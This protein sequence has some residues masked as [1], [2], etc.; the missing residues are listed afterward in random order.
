M[1]DS[2]VR[3]LAAVASLAITLVS[4]WRAA[5]QRP[6]DTPDPCPLDLPSFP[7]SPAERGPGVPSPAFDLRCI[8]LHATAMGGSAR[9]VVEL[10]RVPSPFGVAVS[11]DGHH[12][13]D[14]V[15]RI[16]G[17]PPVSSL[18]P[19]TTYI[20]WATPLE[21]DP[22]IKLGEVTDGSRALGAIEFNK[23]MIF[24][25][26]EPSTDVSE[27]TG[28][29]ILRGRSPSSRMEAHD[30][31]AQAPSAEEAGQAGHTHGTGEDG[32][33]M[34]P[35]YPGI[36]MMAGMMSVR[37]TV[38]PL[39]MEHA[40]DDPP[41]EARPGTVVTLPNGGTLDLAA[42]L[43]RRTIAGRD[44]L[45]L[46]FNGLHPGPLIR[47]DEDATIFVN[48]TNETPFPTAVHWHGV[49][50]DNRFDG[51][52]GVT[53]DPVRPGETFRYTIHFPDAGI[54]W[55]HPHHREDVQQELGLYG[56]MLVDPQAADYYSPVNR[57]EV[58]TLDD[59]LL[60][61]SNVVPFGRESANFALMGRFGNVFLVNAE[62]SYHVAVGRGEVVRFFFTNV[63]NTRTFNV[64]FRRRIEAGR[65]GSGDVSTSDIA[66]GAPSVSAAAVPVK[67]VA[68]DVGKFERE[69]FANSVVMAPAERYVVDVRFDEPGEYALVNHVQGVNHR[70]GVF[71]EELVELGSVSVG[72]QPVSEDHA[73]AFRTLR[74]NDD[75]VMDIDRVRGEFDR[76]VD[77]EIVLSL[78]T[79][80]LQLPLEQSMRYD[81]VWFN[82]VEWTGTMP[83]MNWATSAG[84]VHWL[85]R[86]PSTGHVNEAID[87]RFR[88][89]DVVK[90][91][92]HNDRGAFHA[93]QHP[94][95][96]H[97]Q[98]FLVLEQDGVP[99]TNLAWKDTVLLPTGSV[100]DILLEL[101]NPG[102]WMVHC[103]IAEHL[104]SGMKFV[105]EVE[106]ER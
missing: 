84:E 89:G 88:I 45:M 38:S 71:R 53:Q 54:Y 34:P 91:R 97:G 102:R 3:I 74:V 58:V 85:I 68:T 31:L 70:M 61:A 47:V 9:G 32:W 18:G 63:S 66:A 46:A 16:E 57:D 7:A 82:P 50:L 6:A 39:L 60:D 104:E 51:V 72:S 35:A 106:G 10:R 13:S 26:A 77:H 4:P 25:S 15:I 30:M 100:T 90:V 41:P 36:P 95:H 29:L 43:V 87:W 76:P 17:L 12:L 49:R 20:A 27:R 101:S 92:V 28:P 55:Y 99:N 78:E 80:T 86:E 105:F 93:M 1:I 33:A 67:V 37:P 62:P 79:E 94:L 21:L 81:W 19:Y 96:I 22:V 52:P 64:S 14:H 11:A 24:V 59:L 65:I 73:I 8:E 83:M 56:N 48:F 5:G 69:E 44:L 42:G 23:Y 98:R 40:R 103:H 2:Q 75:V